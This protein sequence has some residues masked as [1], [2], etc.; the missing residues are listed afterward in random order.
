MARRYERGL[1]GRAESWL[2]TGPAAHLA[3]GALDFLEALARYGC[4]RARQRVRDCNRLRQARRAAPTRLSAGAGRSDEGS[5]R[6]LLQ[7]R[8]R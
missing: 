3:G 7:R 2:L 4:A 1:L 6:R 5:L 8:R